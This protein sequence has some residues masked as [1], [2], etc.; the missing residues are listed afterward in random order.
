[1]SRLRRSMAL[2]LS[3]AVA[4]AGLTS[5][6]GSDQAEVSPP[7]TTSPA[8]TVAAEPTG[9]PADCPAAFRSGPLPAGRH[10]G[11]T[12]GDQ[13]RSFH[14]LVPDDPVE[15]PSPLFV[16]LTGTVQEEVAFMEQSGL[17]ALPEDGWVVVAPVRNDNGLIWGPW[18]AMRTPDMTE[19]NPDEALVLDLV[20]C[21]SAH[22]PVDADRV[23]VGGISIGATM[24]NY[25]LQRNSD[26]FAGG[27]VGSGNLILTSPAEPKPL[28]AMTVIV[29]WG[30]DGDQWTGCPD[31]RMGPEYAEVPGCTT[32]DF[33]ADS[34]RAAAYYA[35]QG[36]RTMACQEDVGHIWIAHATPYWAEVLADSPK[37]T[38]EALAIGDPPPPLECQ[39]QAAS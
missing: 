33:V 27:I 24:V 35:G 7:T 14:L 38:T 5:C 10:D 16:S 36:V 32:A 30:G 20:A 22:H 28:E 23:F 25:L 11:F 4:V 19:A 8:P 3:L 18:D 34:Q 39:V 6:S 21:V 17:D 12:S 1:M 26:V 9:D 31:G 37:G 2:S 15:E 13:D 29:A